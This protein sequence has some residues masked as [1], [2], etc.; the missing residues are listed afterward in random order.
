MQTGQ[1]TKCWL[2]IVDVLLFIFI[3]VCLEN[4][5]LIVL[6]CVYATF[7]LIIY[8]SE[9]QFYLKSWLFNERNQIIR[10]IWVGAADLFRNKMSQRVKAEENL[11]PFHWISPPGRLTQLFLFYVLLHICTA[12][13]VAKLRIFFFFFY[14]VS[15][16]GVVFNVTFCVYVIRLQCNV[17]SFCQVHNAMS[18]KRQFLLQSESWKTEN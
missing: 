15:G 1:T 14:S 7:N 3:Y 17:F 11:T 5:R 12:W 6:F 4:T 18:Q 13:T 8:W 9:L 2:N 10:L 16:G